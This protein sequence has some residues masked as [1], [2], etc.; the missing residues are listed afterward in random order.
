MKNISLATFIAEQ[1]AALIRFG[2]FWQKEQGHHLKIIQ[3]SNGLVTG[4][5][6]ST[7]SLN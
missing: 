5:N 2:E 1:Q 4:K 6:V 7:R 3:W